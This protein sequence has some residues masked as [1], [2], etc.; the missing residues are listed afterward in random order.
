MNH[1]QSMTTVI[2]PQAIRNTLPA[3]GNEFVVNIKD[4]SVLNVIAVTELFFITRSAAGSTYKTFQ[5]FFIASV[6][7]FV[8][9]FIA[10][11]LL[12]LLEKY[13]GGAN[14]YTMHK[15]STTMA[16]NVKKGADK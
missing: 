15:S 5:T 6:L 7:Y 3:L 8:M 16:I 1:F 13:M 10:T 9:T 4:T 11:R 2:L 14:S 12:I